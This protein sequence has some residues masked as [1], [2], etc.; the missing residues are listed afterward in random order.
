MTQIWPGR[1]WWSW[2]APCRCTAWGTTTGS[3]PT[4]PA[5]PPAASSGTPS[6]PPQGCSP[7][8]AAKIGQQIW[9]NMNLWISGIWLIQTNLVAVGVDTRRRRRRHRRAGL[10]ERRLQFEIFQLLIYCCLS[11]LTKSSCKI[12]WI[13]YWLCAKIWHCLAI[14]FSGQQIWYD[15]T[16]PK[17]NGKAPLTFYSSEYISMIW[18]HSF[19]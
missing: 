19:L 8:V 15:P 6:T 11:C 3:A 4:S 5:A 9:L 7:P 1:A 17:K 14:L 10:S 12:S 2:W 13:T 18:F 16:V